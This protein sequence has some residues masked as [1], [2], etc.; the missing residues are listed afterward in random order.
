MKLDQLSVP[1]MCKQCGLKYLED[2]FEY[3]EEQIQELEQ[4]L[5]HEELDTVVAM[6]DVLLMDLQLKATL[7][8][9]SVIKT[10]LQR[11]SK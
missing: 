2:K 7:M 3:L 4:L 1:S 10:R 6:E 11:L 9:Q 5:N 8:L